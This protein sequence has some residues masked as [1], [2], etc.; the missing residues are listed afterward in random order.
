[1]WRLMPYGSKY[2]K[3]RP[4]PTPASSKRTGS[5]F[6]SMSEE[7]W[8]TITSAKAAY[9]ARRKRNR[10]TLG[11]KQANVV[12]SFRVG[13]GDFFGAAGSVRPVWALA[14]DFKLS[15]CHRVTCFRSFKRSHESGRP[16]PDIFNAVF[17]IA[18]DGE[19][20]QSREREYRYAHSIPA[21]DRS[22]VVRS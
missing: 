4:L 7:M 3:T 5:S 13:G 18:A 16:Y 9:R 14:L 20:C 12:C 21:I 8:S 22:I 19:S 1:M 15:F 2:R 6:V 11:L 17:Y 10:L